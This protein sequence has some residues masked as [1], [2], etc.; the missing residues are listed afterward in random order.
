MIHAD[1]L[2]LM[3]DVDCLYDKNPRSNPDA[4]S[5]DVVEDIESL[6]ADGTF[7]FFFSSRSLQPFPRFAARHL[8]GA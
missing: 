8:P 5:I 4:R 1:M 3:T 7:F 6:E 2:F